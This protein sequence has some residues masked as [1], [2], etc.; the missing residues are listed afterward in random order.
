M[1]QTPYDLPSSWLLRECSI[2][3]RSPVGLRRWVGGSCSIVHQRALWSVTGSTDKVSRFVRDWLQKAILRTSTRARAAPVRRGLNFSC[4]NLIHFVADISTALRSQKPVHFTL[5]IESDNGQEEGGFS[6]LLEMDGRLRQG[7]RARNTAAC[8]KTQKSCQP[9][10]SCYFGRGAVLG[11]RRPS[12]DK[13]TKTLAG[14]P[15][16][17]RKVL[18][19]GKAR[20][21]EFRNLEVLR[22]LVDYRIVAAKDD[23]GECNPRWNGVRTAKAKAATRSAQSATARVM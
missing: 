22:C 2:P 11:I 3:A 20:C 6:S 13:Q 14:M 19:S 8:C 7:T 17:A 12:G 23:R 4:E 1:K 5:V 10:T 15:R 16:R 18:N 9:R 21:S